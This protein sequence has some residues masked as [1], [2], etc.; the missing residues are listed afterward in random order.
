MVVVQWSYHKICYAL[1]CDSVL[2]YDVILYSGVHSIVQQHDCCTVI[3]WQDRR[4]VVVQY[5]RIRSLCNNMVAVRWWYSKIYYAFRCDNVLNDEVVQDSRIY[6]IVLQHGCC[7]VIVRQDLQCSARFSY[8]FH[9]CNNFVAVRCPYHNIFN[10]VQ[11]SRAW[12]V[13]LC[14]NMVAAPYSYHKISSMSSKITVYWY[15]SFVQPGCRS[16]R[17]YCACCLHIKPLFLPNDISTP[18]VRADSSS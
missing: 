3:I 8:A 7:T 4:C 11:D 1:R 9:S 12:H 16:Y 13:S 10:V 2:N 14:N 17:H 18:G 15:I 5:S 6:S